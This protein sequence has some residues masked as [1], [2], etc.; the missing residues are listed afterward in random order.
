MNRTTVSSHMRHAQGGTPAMSRN[1]NLCN[2]CPGTK[3]VRLALL[4]ALLDIS[5]GAHASELLDLNT[6]GG[7][8]SRAYA[9]NAA[10]DVIVG[11]SS[12]A[13]D[14]AA[15]AFLWSTASGTMTDLGTMGGRVDSLA[16]DVNSAGDV[17][18]GVVSTGGASERAFRWTQATGMVDIGDLNGGSVSNATGVNAAGDVIVGIA[19]DG[20]AWGM[21]RAFR[22]TQAGGMVSLG[23]LNGG[24]HSRAYA[25]NA[26][27]DVVVGYAGDG[28]SADQSRAFRWTQAGGIVS[29]GT[30]G[31]DHSFAMAVNAAGDVVVGH[32]YT[33]GNAAQHAY[34]WTS[35]SGTMADLGTLGG[36]NSNALG[37]NDAGDVVVG[38]SRLAGNVTSRAFRWT[39]AGGMQSIEDWLAA[40]GVTLVG[41]NTLSAAAVNAAGNVVVG[42]LQNSHAFIARVMPSSGGG[43][44]LID[45]EE[46]NNGLA[47]VT[48]SGLLA[49]ND[50]ELAMNGM[51]GNPMRSLLPTGRSS[52]WVGGDVGRLDAGSYDSDMGTAEVGYGYR[53]S[54]ALQLNVAIG[55]TYSKADT[56][57]GGDTTARTSF[58]MPE[59]IVS[60]PSSVYATLSAYY[61]KGTAEIDRAYLNAGALEQ[62][63]ADPGVRSVGARARFDW[64]NAARW[65]DANLTPYAS[66]TY[67][68]TR[69]DGYTEQNVAF[70][71]AWNQRT[72]HATTARIGVDAV[73]PLSDTTTLL[74]RLEAA[75]R[76]ENTGTTTSGQVVGL[77]GFSFAG[78][79]IKQDWLRVGAGFETRVG[80]GVAAVML[81]TSTAGEAPSWWLN[82]SYRW[83]F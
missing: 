35:A 74:G 27:G 73:R 45:V 39:A 22:W 51:H 30:L 7:T 47:R 46:F 20:A 8:F 2:S 54:D 69:M 29:L 38:E 56:G 14:T 64:L 19:F 37:V 1:R 3:L 44:G 50:A 65:G 58:V 24:T 75:H 72:E 59:L 49:S 34:R 43:T 77:Y 26:A 40:A 4:G 81:N 9:V 21:V 12:I 17:V 62:S 63:F 11:Y 36:N 48:N 80:G 32:A 68:E 33:T 71:V 82:A 41:T 53:F 16:K 25:V 15:R 76:F 57:L 28:A 83:M 18:I 79:D 31:G 70:P 60:L 13:G 42:Y 55:R 52:L 23:T 66:L 6:L 78:Q 10:G 5:L 61:G 67:L